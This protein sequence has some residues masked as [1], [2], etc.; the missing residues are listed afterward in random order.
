MELKVI[1][2]KGQENGTVQF[3]DA[4][5]AANGSRAVFH[6]VV[7]AYLAGQRSGTHSTKTRSQVS[8][9]GIKPWKQKGTGRARAGSI[10]SPLWR[11]G[12]VIFGP[13]PRDY[14]QDLPKKKKQLAFRMAVR[15]LIEEKRLQVVEPIQIS[16]PK[17]KHVAAV[18]KAWQAPTDSFY[19]V[20]KVDPVVHRAARNIPT[21]TISD[22]SS[23]NVYDFLRAR[24]VF[25][26]KPALEQLS[27]RIKKDNKA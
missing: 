21:V 16:E 17:T 22:V 3:D 8:G 20:D 26:T 12:G 2:I 18:F 11:H 9:G 23:V 14:A 7:T 24:R 4:L 25:I 27:S 6:E 19:V 5:V 13:T 1:D 10:R 15:D